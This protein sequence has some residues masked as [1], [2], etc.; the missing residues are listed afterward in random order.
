MLIDDV[1][2][3][4]CNCNTHA[5]AS[6]AAIAASLDRYQQRKPIVVNRKTKFIAAG[7]GTWQA[8]K[9]RGWTHIAVVLVDDDASK[10]SGYSLADNR[11]AELSEWDEDRLAQVIAEMEVSDRDLFDALALDDLAA[12]MSPPPAGDAPTDPQPV[13]VTDLYAVLVECTGESDQKRLYDELTRSGRKCR[14]QVL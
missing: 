10:H 14:L 5:E 11:T 1:Q 8:M 13:V 2:P 3:D 12:S 7:E 9:Q 4:P 6:I